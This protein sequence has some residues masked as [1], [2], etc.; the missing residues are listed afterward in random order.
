MVISAEAGNGPHLGVLIL[1]D[2]VVPL[3]L[4]IS[5]IVDTAVAFVL[6]AIGVNH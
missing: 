6:L 3:F 5:H 1:L 4:L 2:V